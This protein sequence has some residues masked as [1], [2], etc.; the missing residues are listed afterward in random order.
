MTRPDFAS[1]EG[2]G[3][4]RRVKRG[5]L[6]RALVLVPLLALAL[7]GCADDA[8]QDTFKPEGPNARHI[9]NLIIPVFGVAAVVFVVILV[10]CLYIALKFRARDSDDYDDMP[11]QIHG[12]VK[13]EIGWTIIP[14]LILVGVAVP[15]VVGV[16]KLNEDPPPEALQ[17][18]VIGQQWWWEYRY[19][20]DNDGQFDDIVT[21][22][23]LVIPAGREIALTITARDV[24][25][26]FWVPKL[27]GKRDAVPNRD[28][29]WKLEADEP[30]EFLGQCTEYCGLSH[31]EMRIKAIALTKDGFETWAD[32]QFKNAATFAKDDE[33]PEAT[34]QR[35][36]LGQLCSSC[37]LIEGVNDDNFGGKG[38][39]SGQIKDQTLQVSRHAPNLTHLMSRTTFA[40]G[41]FDLRKDTPACTARGVEWANTE[42]GVEQCLDRANLEAWLRNPPARKAM[43]PE[44]IPGR[45]GT[46]GMPNLQLTEDQIDL[47][48]TY[49]TTLK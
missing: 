38:E 19:D 2:M 16:F 17:V 44:P 42:E 1:A 41:K 36:F 4:T 23:D 34:G 12:N 22:N 7:A 26:S 48:V 18:E 43:A 45:T 37:H 32:G 5:W 28:H 14:A 3:D 40:G 21:A 25:H 29:P 47:L 35:L 27:N 20:M 13:A 24:I 8:P 39:N 9:D 30:G 6:R 11:K 15:T 49:L 10:G 46:R 33:S 31:A